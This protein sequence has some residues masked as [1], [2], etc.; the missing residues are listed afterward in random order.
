MSGG[1]EQ[2]VGAFVEADG[3]V[4][5]LLGLFVAALEVGGEVEDERGVGHAVGDIADGPAV[6][7][8][9][10]APAIAVELGA[11]NQH[12]LL[13]E[14]EEVGRAPSAPLRFHVLAF[15]QGD[16]FGHFQSGGVDAVEVTAV[17]TISAAEPNLAVA[18]DGDALGIVDHVG[19]ESGDVFIG[20]GVDDEHTGVLAHGEYIVTGSHHVADLA[21]V[22]R[23]G[24]DAVDE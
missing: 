4:R 24:G 8:I 11:E 5:P 12:G 2:T 16:G 18:V 1:D 3:G 10:A 21:G 6:V 13:F 23:A 15:G 22:S 17:G 20:V 7:L 14:G 19:A 9:V